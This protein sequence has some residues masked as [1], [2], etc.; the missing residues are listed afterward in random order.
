MKV[1]LTALCLLLFLGVTSPMY[2]DSGPDALPPGFG[3]GPDPPPPG[4]INDYIP[5]LFV[6]GLVV[7][8][9]KV[10]KKQMAHYYK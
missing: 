8:Y 6:A 9:N 5:W 3:D 1:K 4:P 7:G 2:S 10:N